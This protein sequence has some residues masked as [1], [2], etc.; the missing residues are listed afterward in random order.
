MPHI[1]TPTRI[2]AKIFNVKYYVPRAST[3]R[4]CKNKYP[5]PFRE[6]VRFHVHFFCVDCGWGNLDIRLYNHEQGACMFCDNLSTYIMVTVSCHSLMKCKENLS[7]I[8]LY[9]DGIVCPD[10]R[11]GK[12]QSNIMVNRCNRTRGHNTLMNS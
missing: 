5:K 4:G 12:L 2:W 3:K 1:H 8:K 11:R 7:F 9:L 6:I 10:L